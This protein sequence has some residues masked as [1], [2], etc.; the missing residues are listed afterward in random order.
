MPVRNAGRYLDA[1]VTSIVRQ[2]WH[3]FEFVILDDASTDGS[4]R[5]LRKWRQRDPRIRLIESDRPLGLVG[6]SA[7]VVQAARAPICARMDADDIAVPDRLERQIRVL[8]QRPEVPLVGTLWE[9]IDD[10]GRVVRPRDRGRLRRVSVFAPFPHGSIMFRRTAFD[11]AGGYRPA[12]TYWEDFDLYA[13]MAALG[14]ILVLPDVLYRYRF[15][16]AATTA[17]PDEQ[18]MQAIDAMYRCADCARA[19]TDYDTLLNDAT[20]PSP[21]VRT[22]R[23]VAAARLWAGLP[24]GTLSAIGRLEGPLLRP[25]NVGALAWACWGEFSPRSLRFVLRTFIRLRDAAASRSMPAGVA[26]PWNRP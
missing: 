22:L 13:R 19:R 15:H 18:H 9:G 11:R 8:L 25:R 4:R 6:S 17:R 20:R 21:D 23:S 24:T 16:S 14:P 3:D 1:S 26:M 7:A 12:C 5:A 2:T 10:E